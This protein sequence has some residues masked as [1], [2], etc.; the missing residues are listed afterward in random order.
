LSPARPVP[1]HQLCALAVGD[2]AA[3][4]RRSGAH[5]HP[6]GVHP[7]REPRGHRRLQTPRP[8]ETGGA[9]TDPRD[10][11][12]SWLHAR[13]QAPAAA[14]QRPATHA[15][16]HGRGTGGPLVDETGRPHTQAGRAPARPKA[17]VGQVPGGDRKPARQQGPTESG[18][19]KHRNHS[20]ACAVWGVEQGPGSPARCHG[21]SRSQASRGAGAGI[22]LP[23]RRRGRPAHAAGLT[24][25][26]LAAESKP[27]DLAHHHRT[28]AS[29]G[30]HPRGP[31]GPS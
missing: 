11:G 4:A 3:T 5:A 13:A 20:R 25:G 28:G 31:G 19:G 18:S 21:T 14:R 12:A 17:R 10:R 9:R 1:A 7:G 16:G 15:D 27:R 6:C 23:R 26:C 8:V 29:P 2:T 30:T 22:E 24:S